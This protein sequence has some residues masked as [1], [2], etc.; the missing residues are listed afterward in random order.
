M[1]NWNSARIR[2][3]LLII[4]VVE[5]NIISSIIIY[6]TI[7]LFFHIHI[8]LVAFVGRVHQPVKFNLFEYDTH[9]NRR[10]NGPNGSYVGV[11]MSIASW[12]NLLIMNPTSAHGHIS[13]NQIS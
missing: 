6:S 8:N 7:F 4:A 5:V 13:S 9:H 12:T 2:R 1:N 3:I 10:T 11:K